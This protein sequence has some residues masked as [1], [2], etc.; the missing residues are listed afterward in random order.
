MEKN[1]INILI[2][3]LNEAFDTTLSGKGYCNRLIGD[4][5]YEVC[6]D[7]YDYTCT[8]VQATVY[9]HHTEASDELP[10][11]YIREFESEMSHHLYERRYARDDY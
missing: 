2:D 7:I 4:D 11:N 10:L 6:V 8:V 1:H 9:N 3:M 5:E